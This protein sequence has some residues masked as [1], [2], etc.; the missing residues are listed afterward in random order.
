MFEAHVRLPSPSQSISSS[1]NVSAGSRAHSLASGN[2]CL[3][4]SLLQISV[5]PLLFTTQ[6]SCLP[7]CHLLRENFPLFRNLSPLPIPTPSPYYKKY[8]CLFTYLLTGSDHP[9]TP[10]SFRPPQSEDFVLFTLVFSAL[11]SELG[12]WLMF[13]TCCMNVWAMLLEIPL[14]SFHKAFHPLKL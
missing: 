5:W 4:F 3:S 6:V 10:H 14:R 2:R 8:L 1:L 7:K 11:R 13:G 12:T 9:P